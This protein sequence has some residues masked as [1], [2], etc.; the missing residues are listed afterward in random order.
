MMEAPLGN[1][2]T[3]QAKQS[4]SQMLEINWVG[5]HGSMELLQQHRSWTPLESPMKQHLHP[6]DNGDLTVIPP[7]PHQM[8]Q[9]FGGMHRHQVGVPWTYTSEP[10]HPAQ[11]ELG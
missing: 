9:P 2:P 10:V 1:A 4:H 5:G 7:L 6:V 11:V 8:R 3:V